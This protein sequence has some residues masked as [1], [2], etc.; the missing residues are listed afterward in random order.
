VSNRNEILVALV[1][2]APYDA[3]EFF[4]SR[5]HADR[6][7]QLIAGYVVKLPC[8]IT[9]KWVV[10]TDAAQAETLC[11]SFRQARASSV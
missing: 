8:P 4:V 2:S 6:R 9:G 11:R 3:A 1:S 7:A 5:K 10:L